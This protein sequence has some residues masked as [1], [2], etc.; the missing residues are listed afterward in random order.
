MDIKR[1]DIVFFKNNSLLSR[2]IRLVETGKPWQ[3]VPSHVAIVADVVKNDYFPDKTPEVILIEA[4]GLRVRKYLLSSYKKQ[5]IWY[6]RIK[7]PV[8]IEAGLKWANKQIGKR[9]DFK[10]LIGIY[11]RGFWRLLGPRIY[12]KA[13]K[14]KNYLDSRQQ[15]ICS[16]LVYEDI[17]IATGKKPWDCEKGQATPWDIFRSLLLNVYVQEKI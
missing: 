4:Q 5:K 17:E 3:D 16:E 14:V 7:E 1:G 11:L 6:A 13:R 10:Q 12:E 9:Y 2:T 8:D 15:F